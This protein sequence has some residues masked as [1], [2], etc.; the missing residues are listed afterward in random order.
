MLIPIQTFSDIITNSSSEVFLIKKVDNISFSELK[1]FLEEFHEAH[2]FNGDDWDKLSYVERLDYDAG[3]GMGGIFELQTYEDAVNTPSEWGWS[4]ATYFE[5][6]E[7]K[8]KYLL[9]DSD[10]SHYATNNWILKNLEAI[11]IE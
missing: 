7:D 2:M 4:N 11:Q 3:S 9:V 6:V 1:A 8:D 10:Q 5:E